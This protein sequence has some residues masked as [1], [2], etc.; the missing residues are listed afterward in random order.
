MTTR[1]RSDQAKVLDAPGVGTQV[2]D[3]VAVLTIDNPPVNASTQAIRAALVE[4]IAAASADDGIDAVVI[5]GSGPHF[6]AG[7]DLREFEA[8]DLPAPELPDVI[9][10]IEACSKPVV[11]AMS[12][13]ALGGGL[14]LALGCDYRVAHRST[15]VGF[16]E[17]TLGML[18]GAGGTQ[19][20]LRLLGA[21]KTLDLVT[22]G[23]RVPVDVGVGRDLVDA[24]VDEDVVE[25]A[26]QLARSTEVAK[27]NLLVEDIPKHLAGE[28]EAAAA[29]AIKRRKAAGEVIAAAG[30]VLTGLSAPAPLALDHE[31]A[32]FT[33]LRRSPEAAALR[34]GFFAR[35]SNKRHSR[36]LNPVAVRSVAVIGAGTM[37][38]GIARAFVEAGV[39]VTLYDAQE[40]AAA[41]ARQKLADAQTAL[42]ERRLV[43]PDVASARQRRLLVAEVL[44]DVGVHDLYIEAVFEDLAVKKEV[45][46]RLEDLAPGAPL[47]TNTS[48]LDI[49]ELARSMRSPDRLVGLHF[50]SPAHRTEVVEVIGTGATSSSTMDVALAAAAALDKVPV[51]ARPGPGFIGN[52]IY[53][54]YR[55]QCELMLE[56]GA[57]PAQV[58]AAM[59]DFGFAMGPFAVW[60]MSGLDIAWRAR[61]SADH[62]PGARRPLVLDKLVEHGRLGQKTGAGWYRYADGSHQPHVDPEVD[63]LIDDVS[64]RAGTHRHGP[65]SEE[66]C[67]RALVTMANEASLLLA[68][69]VTDRPTDIDLMLV[70]GYGFPPRKGG[71]SFWTDS[72]DPDVLARD[73]DELERSTGAGFRRGDLS[74]LRHGLS[75]TG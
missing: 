68:E 27:R 28:V 7:S 47:A 3:R 65:T 74:L 29:K 52:R 14:E 39:A 35:Q 46:A 50:F 17:V 11:A 24:I 8:T 1:S 48:Y 45:L 19:R 16:P 60:D 53:N 57:R 62:L 49:E 61:R 25:A 64:R 42:V 54:A 33:R 59:R 43:S 55:W 36:P 34:Y 6:V 2:R 70:L 66:M 32:E 73:L 41:R 56:E 15:V 38:Q 75:T 20:T 21:P 10:A 71:I 67:R 22:C 30:A 51:R 63:E 18:P 12:G 9:A 58:D 23:E 31:R 72:Q 40:G 13:A 4:G 26:V 37:G 5:C 69:G 44:T